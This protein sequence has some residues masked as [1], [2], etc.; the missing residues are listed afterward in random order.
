MTYQLLTQLIGTV[1]TIIIVL[2]FQF[3]SPRATFSAMAVSALF[4]TLHYTM[5]GSAAGALQNFLML[6]RNICFVAVPKG[7]RGEKISKALVL[8][9]VAAV[10]FALWLVPTFPFSPWDFLI[11]GANFVCTIIFWTMDAKKIRTAQFF[12]LS[13]AWL[14]YNIIFGSIPGIFTECFNLVSVVV[15]T[16]R[17]KRDDMK[18]LTKNKSDI[19]K[20]SKIL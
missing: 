16:I 7:G 3:K 5:L 6:I 1:A 8:T 2:S 17:I 12:L 14:T 13:P 19:E 4:F 15:S 18:N 9:A 11:G 10:P 20:N